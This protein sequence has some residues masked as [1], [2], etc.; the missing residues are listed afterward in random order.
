[1]HA[2]TLLDY[3]VKNCGYPFHLIISTKEFLNELVRSF[4]ERPMNTSMVQHR[5]LELV[6]Q[7][8]ATL[9][10]SSRYKNDFKHI[11]DM[12]R[13][14]SYKGYRFPPLSKEAASVLTEPEALK[15]EEELEEED[16]IAQGAKLQELL[17]LGTPAALEQAN[18]LMKIMSGYDTER[19]PDYKK[20]VES[21]IDRIEQRVI[22]LND[23]LNQKK[24]EDRWQ[25]DSTVE[26]LYG[27]A[28]TA[29]PRIQK[30]IGDG[31]D[32]ERIA[33]LLELND[34]INLVINKYEEFKSGKPITRSDA[35]AGK[36]SAPPKELNQP[37]KAGPISLIDL[38]DWSAPPTTSPS[39]G[40]SPASATSGPSPGTANL[41]ATAGGLGNLLDDLSSLNFSSNAPA[42]PSQPPGYTGG[43]ASSS[44]FGGGFAA[45]GAPSVGQAPI[46]GQQLG[47]GSGPSG[48][49][50]PIGA[51]QLAQPAFHGLVSFGS[52]SPAATPP[53]GTTPQPQHKP[54]TPQTGDL[55]SGISQKPPA[56]QSANNG[57]FDLLGGFGAP[58][59]QAATGTSTAPREV[60]I[61]D[62]NGLQIK[63]RLTSEPSGWKAE[64]TFINVTPVPF[65]DLEFQLAVPKSMTLRM[66]GLSG[67]TVA[68]L[69]Q[70][71]VKQSMQIGNPAKESL[72]VRFKVKYA[73]N[74]AEVNEQGEYA[75]Q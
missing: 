28:K 49:P 15:T 73:V 57:G 50:K 14:L 25:R 24:P 16:K 2:L 13:L 20:E 74:G 53:R 29:Q 31:D 52:S 17:R 41:P 56:A 12:Y 63:F 18:D 1:M 68:P 22:L 75:D 38:D 45:F 4:P 46:G 35:E 26:E 19:R 5:I 60:K 71:Q 51:G 59:Q 27:S 33:R 62:K 43:T 47:L 21:E 11:N 23:M 48:T 64:A 72:R 32:D 58:A 34:L 42:G 44:G 54:A 36:T 40:A 66:D 37:S 9:C 55:F 69:N 70:T 10:V 30:L 6:Q 61:F 3:C 67:T 8:N 7:W 65:T 39:S